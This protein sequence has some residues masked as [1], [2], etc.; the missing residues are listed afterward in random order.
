GR[1]V[2]VTG[3]SRGLGKAVARRLA[4][5]GAHVTLVARGQR[6][7][8]AAVADLTAELAQQAGAVVPGGTVR[9]YAADVADADAMQALYAAHGLPDWL[10]LCAGASRPGYWATRAHRDE[11]RAQIRLNYDTATQPLRALVAA[12]QLLPER[13]VF[14]GSMASFVALT[15]YA[16]YCGSKYALRGFA[17][18]LRSEWSPFAR[19]H[20]HFYLPSNM[21]TPGY[22]DENAT[23]PA[24]THALDGS[25][26]RMTPEA[27]ADR[28]LALMASGRYYLANTIEGELIRI[29]MTDVIPRPSP[30]MECLAAPVLSFAL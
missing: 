5:A 2:V 30:F 29:A 25:G 10:V 16:T 26:G 1:H 7:L 4:A 23:K 12:R 19:T 18:A 6:D 28:M 20:I 15:G 9:A 21:D 14:V 8:D 11:A 13:I 22:A 3:G 17:N 27:A 24:I